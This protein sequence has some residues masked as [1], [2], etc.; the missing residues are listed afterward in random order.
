LLYFNNR[1][2]RQRVAH[3]ICVLTCGD[4]TWLL[5]LLLLLLQGLLRLLLLLLLLRPLLQGLLLLQLLQE[6]LV[7][8]LNSSDESLPERSQAPLLC[9]L[10]AL[11]CLALPAL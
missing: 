5:L 6:G 3:S 7:R 11:I 2:I 10:C 9:I 8:R 1:L 4:V